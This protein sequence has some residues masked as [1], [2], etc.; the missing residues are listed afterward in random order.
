MAATT[1]TIASLYA[2]TALSLFLHY[3]HDQCPHPVSLYRDIAILGRVF[4]D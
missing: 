1:N 4:I 3:Q 2:V